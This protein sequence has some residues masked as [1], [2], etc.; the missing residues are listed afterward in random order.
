MSEANNGGR[1]DRAM[2]VGRWVVIRA[3]RVIRLIRDSDTVGWGRTGTHGWLGG[4]DGHAWVVGRSGRARIPWLG[5][6]DGHASRGWAERTGLRMSGREDE[7]ASW[8][9]P[10]CPLPSYLSRLTSPVLPLT[11]G[12][13]AGWPRRPLPQMHKHS[14]THF[15]AGCP[16]GQERVRVRRVI[17]HLLSVAA[18]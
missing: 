18:F 2:A 13:W 6:A 16:S 7:A 11:E 12:S 17:D 15:L 1:G 4:A 3:I 5:G 14:G 10:V 9:S 8:A